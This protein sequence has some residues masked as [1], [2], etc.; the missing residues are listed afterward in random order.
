MITGAPIGLVSGFW[1]SVP[2]VGKWN[3]G[4]T[5]SVRIMGSAAP[6]VAHARCVKEA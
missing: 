4:L 1:F 5:L 6:P 2:S 3:G